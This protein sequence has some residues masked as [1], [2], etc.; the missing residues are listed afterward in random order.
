MVPGPMSWAM[1]PVLRKTPAPIILATTK[2]TPG[3]RLSGLLSGGTSP[4][5]TQLGGLGYQRS[6][7][8]SRQA[9]AVGGLELL[10]EPQL[11]GSERALVEAEVPLW[12]AREPD[13]MH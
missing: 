2:P 7:I 11:G 12:K 9:E 10:D 8:A 1:N 4:H 5:V 6:V 3:Q 13:S